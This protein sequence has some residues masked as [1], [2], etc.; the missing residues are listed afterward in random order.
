MDDEKHRMSPSDWIDKFGDL[1]K[2][3]PRFNKD[4]WHLSH[5]FGDKRHFRPWYDDNADYNTNAKS[6]Y[7]YLGFRIRQLDYI[8][9]A[10]N[11]LMRRDVQVQDTTTVDM[12][13]DGDWLKG[14]DVETVSAVVKL[15]EDFL[16]ALEV[17]E[18][19]LYVKDL[20]PE[21]DKIRQDLAEFKE[22]TNRRLNDDESQLNRLR[23]DLQ[24]VR[25]GLDGLRREI[26]NLQ[27]Q[28]Q[29]ILDRLNGHYKTIPKE[30]WYHAFYNGSE[31]VPTGWGTFKAGAIYSQNS[32]TLNVRVPYANKN[33]QN[34]KL[35]GG[36]L[37]LSQVPESYVVGFGF[38][39]KYS[40]LND[41]NIES[42]TI[43]NGAPHILPLE[44]RAAWTI[45]YNLDHDK[46]IC[47]ADPYQV[48]LATFADGYNDKNTFSEH[49]KG[50][51]L[52]GDIMTITMTLSGSVPKEFWDGSQSGDEPDEPDEPVKPEEP[53]KPDEPKEPEKPDEPKEPEKPDV[54][55]TPTSP[56]DPNK[57][58]VT[59]DDPQGVSDLG[60]NVTRTINL[61]TNDN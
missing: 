55:I 16:N 58:V 36:A 38:K 50:I 30:H 57:I 47:N 52:K 34:L 4:G 48:T 24:N 18:N 44:Q 33:F 54:P 7:D 42:V 21:I 11:S 51:Y 39:D 5:W 49:Y 1:E 53:E 22:A 14:D 20:E 43:S 10:I 25:D 28:I 31:D 40:F 3:D 32:V 35:N 8:V 41:M 26:K 59:E 29:S 23:Q 61:S 6:Y 56:T 19:G 15:S 37:P 12:S 2:Y 13:R 9:W 46:K 27:S 60:R 45:G 17:H